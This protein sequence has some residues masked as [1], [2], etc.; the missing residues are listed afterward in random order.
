MRTWDQQQQRGRSSLQEILSSGQRLIFTR[1]TVSNGLVGS[2]HWAKVDGLWVREASGVRRVRR[3]RRGVGRSWKIKL[4][5][6]AA[7]SSA[8]GGR[9][10]KC[11]GKQQT[12]ID[13]R[14]ICTFTK[15][16]QQLTTLIAS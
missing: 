15:I 9:M 14:Q 1:C 11:S 8:T 5:P 16:Y 10:I 4:K 3:V 12:H 6:A 7:W 13:L 2:L